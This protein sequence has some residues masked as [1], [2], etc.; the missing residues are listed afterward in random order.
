MREILFRGKLK[1]DNRDFEKGAWLCGDLSTIKDYFDKNKK[2]FRISGADVI[3][4]TVGQYTG[5]TDK[6]GKGIFEGD[7]VARRHKELL[8]NNQLMKIVFC[9]VKACFTAVDIGGGNET[10]ISD[11]IND[12]YEIEVVGNIYDNPG[13]L[14]ANKFKIGDMVNVIDDGESYSFYDSWVTKNAVEYAVYFTYGCGFSATGNLSGRLFKIV[15]VAPHG[16]NEDRMLYL[17]QGGDKRC[18]LVNEE[19][20]EQ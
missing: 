16:G 15:S 6:N 5:F 20:I 4:K 18:Y 12:K 8:N 17:I 13:L 7:I 9:P 1:N 14:C 2:I 3:T 11:Y 19:A 10:F